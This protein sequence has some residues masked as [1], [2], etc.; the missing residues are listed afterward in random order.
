MI[1]PLTHGR[2]SIIDDIDVELSDINWS[3]H[4]IKNPNELHGQ[5]YADGHSATM[6][7]KRKT[8]RLHRLILEKMLNRPLEKNEHVDHINHDSLDNRRSNLR[9]ATSQQ[10]QFNQRIRSTPK[11]SK[12]RG[13]AWRKRAGKW[14]AQIGCNRKRFGLG[15][16]STEEEAARAYDRKAKELFGSFY[17]PIFD[18]HEVADVLE[19]MVEEMKK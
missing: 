18:E 15:Y 12:Y 17:C 14:I 7:G 9:L 5:W 16:F 11:S 6:N 13:V 19:E 10:N 3:A 4:F 2:V 8:I 1:I